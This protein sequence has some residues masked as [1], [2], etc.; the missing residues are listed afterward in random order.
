MYRIVHDEKRVRSRR[1]EL[2][3]EGQ[4]LTRQRV[5][6]QKVGGMVR[7]ILINRWV[8]SDQVQ[9]GSDGRVVSRWQMAD[10]NGGRSR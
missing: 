1:R 6:L 7:R 8:R 5:T 2:E 4:S 3:I 9:R 10:A